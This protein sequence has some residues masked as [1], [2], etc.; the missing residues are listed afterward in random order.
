MSNVG[1]AVL[2]NYSNVIED[3]SI[4]VEYSVEHNNGSTSVEQKMMLESFN[5]YGS[6]PQWKA[7]IAFDSFPIQDT[8]YDAAHKLADWMDRLADAIR[9]GNYELP[10]M[11]TE[12][13]EIDK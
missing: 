13:K 8:A 10:N 7:R 4:L 12:F 5:S 3:G 6:K 2:I 9:C 11:G 1:R